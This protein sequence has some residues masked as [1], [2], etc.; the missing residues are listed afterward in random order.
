MELLQAN[1]GGRQPVPTGKQRVGGTARRWQSFGFWSR[2]VCMSVALVALVILARQIGLGVV[3]VR[4]GE[5]TVAQMISE[6]GDW[7]RGAPT[8]GAEDDQQPAKEQEDTSTDEML[9]QDVP[10]LDDLQQAQQTAREQ[11]YAFDRTALPPDVRAIVPVNL[12]VEPSEQQQQAALLWQMQGEAPIDG[13]PFV[14]IVHAHTSEGYTSVGTKYLPMNEVV[15]R[16][17]SAQTSVIGVG[18]ALVSELEQLGVST[19]HITTSFDAVGNAG[20]FDRAAAQISQ[21]L[22]RYPTIRYV[23]DLHRD[24]GLDTSGNVLRAVTLYQDEILAQT[25]LLASGQESYGLAA[26]LA[27]ELN[28]DGAELCRPV[29]HIDRQENW[30][31]EGVCVLRVEVGTA[32]NSPD[33]ARRAVLP[34]ARALT[35]VI[36]RGSPEGVHR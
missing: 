25:R 29:E 12:A 17:T 21:W 11:L 4:Q 5:I 26:A 24:A 35:D 27:E 18:D 16:S 22:E 7:L 10:T 9:P 36:K 19:Y 32:G 33:E 23:I 1:S 6:L 28:K 8:S 13:E 20:A 14:L 15:G 2:L 30:K 31:W 34:L 3:R